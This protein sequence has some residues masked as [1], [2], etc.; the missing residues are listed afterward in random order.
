M[1]RRAATGSSGAPGGEVKAHHIL[2]LTPRREGRL[3]FRLAE[4]KKQ[5]LLTLQAQQQCLARSNALG[6]LME[7]MLVWSGKLTPSELRIQ[8]QKLAR[9]YL[10]Q[11]QL[12][13]RQQMLM[14]QL[15]KLQA[16]QNELMLEL[17]HLMSGRDNVT[18]AFAGR[19]TPVCIIKL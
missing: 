2:P 19:M 18:D 4:L 1:R 9:I 14:R 8:K 10:Q 13:F 5:Y 15:E 7:K 3:G 6:M 16:R 12:T 11:Q 17:H